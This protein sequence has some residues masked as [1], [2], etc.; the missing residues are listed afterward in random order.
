MNIFCMNGQIFDLD[1]V[2]S[3]SLETSCVQLTFRNGDKIDLSWRDETERRDILRTVQE[4][5]PQTSKSPTL[6]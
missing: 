2:H 3:T 1:E 4:V 5:L 6:S